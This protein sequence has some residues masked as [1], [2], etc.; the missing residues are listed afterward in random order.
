MA[1]TKEFIEYVYDQLQGSGTIRYKKM[2]G[3]YGFYCD[4]VYF[5]MVCDDRFLVK[6]TKAGKALLPNGETQLPYVGGKPCFYITEL[7]NREFLRTFVQ[8]TC[9]ELCKKKK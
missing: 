1:S 4:E 7:D 3:E 5:A 2:F 8:A 9:D 6:I